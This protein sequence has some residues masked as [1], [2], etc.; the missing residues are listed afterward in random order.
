MSKLTEKSG[1]RHLSILTEV[2]LLLL[3]AGLALTLRFGLFPF[4]YSNV[5]SR[6]YWLMAILSTLG[7]VGSVIIHEYVHAFADKPATDSRWVTAGRCLL[8]LSVNLLLALILTG[9]AILFDTIGRNDVVI[10]ILFH[11]GAFNVTLVLFEL[12]P[13]LPLDGGHILLTLFSKQ[14]QPMPRMAE[15]LFWSG[16]AIG[17][18]LI[19]TSVHEY[20]LGRPFI[21]LW[22]W[23]T[24]F[25]LAKASLD[26]F[27]PSR[28]RKMK[29]KPHVRRTSSKEES[30]TRIIHS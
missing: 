20:L 22:M 13:A 10:G 24:G 1:T 16:L 25:V 5:D 26:A 17:V 2:S 23:L 21:S 28:F 15:T 11:L 6:G 19:V 9:L 7:M 12:L 4:F 3:I 27:E 18:A 8:G 29:G 14:G 30:A